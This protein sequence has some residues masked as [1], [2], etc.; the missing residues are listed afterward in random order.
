MRV[1]YM[2]VYCK[3]RL[4]ATIISVNRNIFLKWIVH[5]GSTTQVAK[6]FSLVIYVT[7][8]PPFI[9][10][11]IRVVITVLVAAGIWNGGVIFMAR[12]SR[13][14]NFTTRFHEYHNEIPYSPTETSTMTHLSYRSRICWAKFSYFMLHFLFH[15]WAV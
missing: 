4:T 6:M 7:Q 5:S 3:P 15:F 11:T 9:P 8:T 14:M 2:Y 12:R 10:S 13:A 1:Y